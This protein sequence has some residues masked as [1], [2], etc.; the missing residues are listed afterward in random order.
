MLQQQN[1]I[2]QELGNVTG[3][4]EDIV[5]L[6]VKSQF[7]TSERRCKKSD[8][9]SDLKQKLELVTGKVLEIRLENSGPLEDGKMLGFYSPRDYQTL[10]VTVA[11]EINYEDVN[12]VQKLEMADEEYDKRQDSVREFKRRHRLGRFAPKEDAYDYKLEAES[13][14]VGDRCLVVREDIDGGLEKRASVAFV[15]TTS[16]KPGYWVGVSYDEPLGKHNGSVDG[17][18]YFNCPNKHGAFVRP[19][20]VTV[21]DYP[22]EDIFMSDDEEF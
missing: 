6:F 5:R 17:V 22:E 3:G 18:V 19:N 14:N 8:L 13:I 20:L 1:S 21:G 11:K 2:I 4:G 15:G 12:Q 16:F 10:Y 7:S 9:I